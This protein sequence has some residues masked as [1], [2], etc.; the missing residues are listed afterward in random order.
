[1]RAVLYMVSSKGGEMLA[2]ISIQFRVFALLALLLVSLAGAIVYGIWAINDVASIG[3]NESQQAMLAGERQ[4][5]KVATDAMA[6]GLGDLLKDVPEEEAQVA[7]I[8]QAVDSFRFEADSSGYFFVYK[9]TV[10]V[11]LPPK[12]ELQGRDLAD[13]KD[14]NGVFF[15]QELAEKAAAGGGFV[16]YVF[17]KPTMGDQPKLSYS[18]MIPGTRFWIGTGVYIDNVLA[19]KV[20]IEKSIQQRT[21]ENVQ[22]M[23]LASGLFFLLFILPIAL[24][25]IR[26]VVTPIKEATHAAQ[27]VAAGHLDT[28]ITVHGKNEISRL[29]AALRDMVATLKKNMEDISQKTAMAQDKARQAQEATKQAQAASEQAK[30]A[31]A[32]G[33]MD[34]ATR[35]E[36]IATRL[37]AAMEEISAQ[38]DVIT[39]STMEQQSRIQSTATGMEELRATVGDVARNASDAASQSAHVQEEAR[40]GAEV[41]TKS[42]DSMDATRKQAERLSAS[43]GEL[44]SQAQAIGSILTTINDIADQ[45]NLLALNAA[46]EAARA[47]EAGRGF[48]VVADEV[49]KLAEKTV[50]ATKEV[51]QSITAIQTAAANNVEGMGNAAATMAKA[52]A[53]ANES[54]TFLS[55]I[56]TSAQTAAGQ[57]Q[58]IATA[59]E[60]QS[61]TAEA[62]S[63]ALEEINVLAAETARQIEGSHTVLQELAEQ[64]STMSA[65]IESL[66]HEGRM[67]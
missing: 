41:V 46:I 10:N 67:A 43:M 8:R 52:A 20:K 64:A 1:M 29:Q 9:G 24:L 42:I 25:I 38:S 58:S 17:D 33:M 60:E 6:A 47:G 53:M 5:L 36:Q 2:N 49:R 50:A 57:V 21:D 44:D 13:V 34:A 39:Q 37:A 66:K 32:E 63:Q 54:G 11:A 7:L 28:V 3:V 26:S 40:K 23:A 31:K 55:S 56:V 22:G 59:A 48:A 65:M 45:T 4:K 30:T 16:E 18:A 12:K 35:L 14:P 19:A 62:F 15:V 61:A 51:G 27:E